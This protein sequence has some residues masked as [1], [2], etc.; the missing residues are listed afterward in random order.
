M[1]YFDGSNSTNRI[2]DVL[3]D[4]RPKIILIDE[5]DKMAKQFHNKLL[6]MMENGKIK[7]DQKNCQYDFEIKSLKVFLQ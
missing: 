4:V 6:N 2:L 1:V 7:V 3:D 5:I